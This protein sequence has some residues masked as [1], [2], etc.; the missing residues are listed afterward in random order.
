M[1]R[2][3]FRCRIE[4]CLD[5]VSEIATEGPKDPYRTHKAPYSINAEPIV[6]NFSPRFS[7]LGTFKVAI[8]S[9]NSNYLTFQPYDLPPK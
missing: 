5:N 3:G 4:G 7:I 2:K 8:A 6:T 9:A 1:P